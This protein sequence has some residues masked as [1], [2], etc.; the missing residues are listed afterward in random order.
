MS[1][2][3]EH[4]IVFEHKEFRGRH[5]HIFGYEAN[6]NDAE[7]NSLNDRISSF[8]V[9]SGDWTVFRHANFV[10][11]VGGRTFGPGQYAWVE[12]YNVPN[13]AISSLRATG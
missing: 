7:D 2:R 12:D 10:E 1:H 13:D 5:R 3:N 9:L 8:V 4:I 6:L 11:P